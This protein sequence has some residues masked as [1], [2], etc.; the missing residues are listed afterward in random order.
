MRIETQVK[1]E[2]TV[3]SYE[4]TLVL[5]SFLQLLA[6]DHLPSGTTGRRC[7][8]LRKQSARLM[9]V[10]FTYRSRTQDPSYHVRKQT[11]RCRDQNTPDGHTLLGTFE[12]E[13]RRLTVL[14]EGEQV[15]GA[16]EEE[17]V[18]GG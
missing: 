1:S 9:S 14:S 5:G 12:Q 6:Q 18:S 10:M 13:A 7:S 8:S 2:V 4:E 17:S 11:N 15:T 16:A 3:V